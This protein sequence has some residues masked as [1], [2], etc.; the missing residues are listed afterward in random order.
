MIVA[1]AGRVAAT[2]VA[3]FMRTAASFAVALYEGV[4]KQYDDEDGT[5]L[6]EHHAVVVV[7]FLYLGDR[8]GKPFS[9]QQVV[10]EQSESHSSA[11]Y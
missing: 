1:G 10:G 6:I 11:N 7:A 5:Q 9:R 8:I 2:V 3:S 4:G